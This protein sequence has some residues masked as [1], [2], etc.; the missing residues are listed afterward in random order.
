MK[1]IYNSI[2]ETNHAPTVSSIAGILQ[3]QFVAQ[4][5]LFL[6]LKLLV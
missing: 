3:L 6:M 1:G 2:P 5:T 4:V